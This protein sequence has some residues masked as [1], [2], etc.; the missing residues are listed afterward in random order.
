MDSVATEEYWNSHWLQAKFGIS[1]KN[2]PIRRWIEKEIKDTKVSTCLEIGCYPGKFLSVMGE[3]GYELNG[4]DSFKGTDLLADYFKNNGYRVGNFYEADFLNFSSQTKYD[5]VCSFGFIEHFENVSAILKKH[6]ELLKTGGM[7]VIDVP[8][9][10]S[11]I[12][13][14]L[15]KILEPGTLEN[16]VMTTM[17]LENICSELKRN[18]CEIRYAG[19]IGYFYF[20]YVNRHNK[21]QSLLAAIINLTRPFMVLLPESLYKRYIGIIAIKM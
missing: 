11:A 1:P 16:H 14:F 17:D 8:N 15:Y 10:N 4:I 7:L 3:K 21:I 20:R 6:L 19:Y 5:V 13:R 18:G 2:H 12:Y 9:L